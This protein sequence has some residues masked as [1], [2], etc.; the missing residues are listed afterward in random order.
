VAWSAR[1][2]RRISSGLGSSSLRSVAMPNCTT[3]GTSRVEQKTAPGRDARGGSQ[4][5][6]TSGRGVWTSW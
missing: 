2:A 1:Q 5:T 6:T 3:G 4:E